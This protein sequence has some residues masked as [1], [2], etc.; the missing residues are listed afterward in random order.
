MLFL[1]TQHIQINLNTIVSFYRIMYKSSC[2]K[3]ATRIVSCN[4]NKWVL[5]M[6]RFESY[7]TINKCIVLGFNLKLT[8][9][10]DGTKT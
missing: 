6:L 3:G 8:Q 5:V 10:D 9:F 7:D 4:S 1:V 2:L